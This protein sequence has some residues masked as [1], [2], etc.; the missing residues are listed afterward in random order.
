MR[1]FVRTKKEGVGTAFT[2]LWG[3]HTE[4]YGPI[5]LWVDLCQSPLLLP[6]G[7]GEGVGYNFPCFWLTVSFVFEYKLG[8]G[9]IV[10]T[11]NLPN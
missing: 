11:V 1:A 10:K 3:N 6:E 9:T 8:Q 7:E 4:I 2:R 5:W